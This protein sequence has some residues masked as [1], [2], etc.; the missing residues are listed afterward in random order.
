[1]V[2]IASSPAAFAA[3]SRQFEEVAAGEADSQEMNCEV[4]NERERRLLKYFPFYLSTQ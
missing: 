2:S 4:L 3:I 1:V